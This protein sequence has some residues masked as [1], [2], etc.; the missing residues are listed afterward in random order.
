MHDHDLS[1][2][3][4]RRQLLKRGKKGLIHLVF[5]RTGIVT[6]LLLLQLGLMLLVALRFEEYLMHYYSTFS[7]LSFAIVIWL[8]NSDTDPNAK[9]TWLVVVLLAPLPGLLLYL[10]VR[11]DIGHRALRDRMRHI[12]K[13]SRR[14]IPKT[15]ADAAL[16]AGRPEDAG[17]AAYLRKAGGFP[18]YD[19]TTVDYYPVGEAFFPAFLA[20]L[21]RAESYIFLEYFIIE[22]GKMWD[23]VE[24]ILARKAKAG[25]EVRVL[26][27][28]TCEFTK[29]PHSFPQ[30][31]K[32]LGIKCRV[33]ARVRP[34]VST[35]YNYRDHRKIAVIDGRVAYTGGINLADEY[36]NHTH[37]FGH[38]KD[39]AIRLE[40]EA[41]RSFLQMFLQMWQV[42]D[43]QLSFE[44]Y[45]SAPIP[46]AEQAAGWV[47]PYGDCPLD[48]QPVGE[49]VYTHILNQ[50]KR[51][52]HIMTP[53]LILG[54]ELESALKFAAQRGVEV[55]ILLPG[56]PDKKLAFALA[57]GHYKALTEAG[58]KIYEYAPGF[59]HAKS[60]LADREAA[61]VGS[62]NMDYRSFQ[63][64][65]ECGTL[66][67]HMPV[68][69]ELLEDMDH[70]MAESTLYTMEEWKKRSW[71]R[72][73]A[74]SLLR[75]GAIWL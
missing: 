53:Y 14:S 41:V 47:I 27:D 11:N 74:A 64:H 45:L 70:I 72:R 13:A 46:P 63:L 29:L 15:A 56:I 9:I 48:D 22:N 61:F 33:F 75:L 54:H 49:W 6:L 4:K 16:P 28:G 62:V 12:A 66:M 52:V 1:P 55:T 73:S 67:Y 25:V 21:E 8:L 32:T 50:A 60:V 19:K 17:L 7:L 10:Y 44:P 39:T 59:L 51:Y 31:L 37:P 34:F 36:I 30:Y 26:Y 40:G 3:E 58:V 43:R 71:F 5:S 35:H 69:E 24:D 42:E 38:W 57:K 2:A 68:V 23:A 65:Y 20:D 18:V